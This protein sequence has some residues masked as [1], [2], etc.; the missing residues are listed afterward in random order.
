MLVGRCPSAQHESTV[1]ELESTKRSFALTCA[2]GMS[3]GKKDR[4]YCTFESVK[5]Q[6]VSWIPFDQL[7]VS[8]NLI[9]PPLA[10]QGF[11]PNM[12]PHGCIQIV[13]SASLHS[14]AQYVLAFTQLRSQVLSSELPI[15]PA[16]STN[17]AVQHHNRGLR[18][19]ALD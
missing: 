16:N 4:A 18:L 9:N 3:C 14:Q 1:H 12:C 19:S 5:I 2:A 13:S 11:A 8:A 7:T 15:L 17:H 6:S 10:L